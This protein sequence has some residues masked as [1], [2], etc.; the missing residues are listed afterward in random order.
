MH[1]A[2]EKPWFRLWLA[3]LLRIAHLCK[4]K[5]G[6]LRFCACA[7]CSQ[8]SEY[9]M[10]R[11]LVPFFYNVTNVSANSVGPTQAHSSSARGTQFFG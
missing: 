2:E 1:P 7:V 3:K 9:S 8:D 11:R 10:R 4:K 5:A 6:G